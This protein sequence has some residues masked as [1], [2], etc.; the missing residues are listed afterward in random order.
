MKRK[1]NAWMFPTTNWWNLTYEDLSMA[2]TGKLRIET[3]YLLIAVRN[4]AIRSNNVKIF[5][6]M[7]WVFSSGP[8]DQGTIPGRVI[9]KTQKMIL[10]TALFNTQHYKVRIKSKVEQS[11]EWS[12]TLPQYLAVVAIEKVPFGHPR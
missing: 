12:S 6:L 2:K 5:E 10:D 1:T 11:R 3:G 7:S 9:L 4:N 8:G